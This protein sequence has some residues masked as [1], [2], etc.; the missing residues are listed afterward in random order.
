VQKNEKKENADIWQKVCLITALVAA[1][2]LFCTAH[3]FKTGLQ[4]Q[5][6]R[7][8]FILGMLWGSLTFHRGC[9]N[10]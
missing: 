4:A 2:S 3:F 7:Q 6:R 1:K 5:W 10:I 8:R 9:S